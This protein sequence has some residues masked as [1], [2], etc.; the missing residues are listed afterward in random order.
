ME[1]GEGQQQP[2]EVDL[3]GAYLRE[4]DDPDWRVKKELRAGVRIGVGV[5]LPR[6]PPVFEEKLKWRLPGRP[7]AAVGTLTRMALSGPDARTMLQRGTS[8]TRSAKYSKIWR[9]AARS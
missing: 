5:G 6:T 8:L 1:S 4:C 9:L 2:I 7:P 3:L